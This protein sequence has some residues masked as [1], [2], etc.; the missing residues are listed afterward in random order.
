[1]PY[2]KF[3][4]KAGID[5]EGTD[6]TN[7]GGWFDS[8]LV[9]FRKGFA[10]K[11]GGWAKNTTSSFLGTCRNLFAWISIAGTKY[12]FLGTNLKAYVQEGSSFYDITPIRLTTS[13]GDVTFSA[14]D[15]DATITVSDTAHGAVQH[16]FVTFSGAVSLGG[17][18][19]ATV[20]NQEY[21][22]TNIV[23]AN[24]YLIEAKDTSGD[25]VLANSSDTGNGGSSVVG[26]YQIN[27]GLDNF[28][29]STG[30][31]VN[32]WGEAGFGE[33]AS[34]GFANQ[35][36]LWSSDN[37]GEDLI[38]HPRGGPVFYWDQS[39]GT[40][41][42]AVNI[43]S[44]SGANLA[45]TVGLQTIVSETDRH[46]FVL[47]A[48]PINDTGTAR[49]GAIDPM[50]VAFSDQE[51]I[52]EW[53]PQTTN[54]AGS[55]RLSV[56]SEIIGGI[57]SRQETLVW[58]DSALYSIQFVGP[59]LTFAVNLINQGVGMIAPNACI[60]AP[61]GVYWMAED[62]FYR[63][64]GS[65]Q[66]LE[67]TV[68]SYVQ[69][70]LNLSQLYK[71]FALSNK[72]Y[73]EIWWFYPSTQDNT[74]EISRYVIYN[75]LENTWSIGELVRTAWLDEDVFVAP[76]ATENGYLYNQETGEDADGS[77]M[78]NVF[79]E[80][81]DFDLQEGNDFAFI[82][83]I[84]PDIKFYGTNTSSGGPLINMQI[85]TRNF[86]AQ[87]LST[88][89]TKDVSNNTNELNVRARAR[90]AVLRLQSDDD[91]DT[92]NRL[93]VQWRLGYTRMYIQPDG[94]R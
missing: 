20:L 41:V 10:E 4:F 63:Y 85:K 81:S 93:G 14:T 53:E 89:V 54:T 62:G 7:A 35:L 34:L 43:T 19:T 12:L 83:K 40:S 78:D 65:V 13:A 58:T 76:L 82:S 48:D 18:I 92:G 50:L 27:T 67:C 47:G 16:D 25:P 60:N 74:G 2:A 30:W 8:S 9:R 87:S 31:G 72:Q 42:R 21:Q 80:S 77:P 33:A 11:I 88:K 86:P 1:M 32:S 52:T 46:V 15:G 22:I 90:Q 71:C 37:F 29:S 61:N 38:L 75:Y 28:V 91:A 64:N 6:Y 55:V 79:I 23:D 49:T 39:G 57:R 94:R 73:N 51:S 5:R 17:N 45:P 69:E 59:P 70:N 24:S 26:A 68:L 3:Q 44:L 36:R 66:R 56:G 84:I